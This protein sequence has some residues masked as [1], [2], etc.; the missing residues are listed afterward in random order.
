MKIYKNISLENLDG[1][2]CGAVSDI[3]HERT[4]LHVS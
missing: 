4:W 3:K 2:S 1:I